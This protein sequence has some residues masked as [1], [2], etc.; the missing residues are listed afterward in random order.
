MTSGKMLDLFHFIADRTKYVT[1]RERVFAEIDACL[2]NSSRGATVRRSTISAE[3]LARFL[4]VMP[5]D[6]RPLRL[7]PV[8]LGEQD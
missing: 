4:G 5:N 7:P 3:I 1:G 2:A 6:E 8:R